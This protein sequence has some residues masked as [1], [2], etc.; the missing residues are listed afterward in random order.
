MRKVIWSL[1]SVTA[2]ALAGCNSST[3]SPQANGGPA[4][5]ASAAAPQANNKVTG[6]ITLREPAQLSPQAKLEV[7][8]VDVSAAPTDANGD[9]TAAV[10]N[11]PIV[12][13]TISPVG[14]FPV[15]FE[16]DFDPAKIN[17][18]NLYVVK[19]HM[20]DGDRNYEMPLQ[21][22]VLTKGASNQVSIQLVAQQTPAEKDLAAFED[23][24]KQIGGMKI[25]SGTK[26]E[27]DASRGWQVFRRDGQVQFIREQVDY[28]DKGFTD[29]DYAYKAGKP[30]VAVQQKKSSKDAKTGST[31]QVSWDV[32]GKPVLHQVL[33]GGKT[34]DLSDSEAASLKSQAENILKLA[35]K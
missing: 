30:W 18:N 35:G 21:A 13:K 34:S 19:A 4:D 25:K 10:P 3:Q 8:L 28:G 24:K 31:E 5:A 2:L 7:S 9:A 1:V 17:P 22:P 12:T 32:D 11:A 26:L 27:K 16:L 29:T 14:S 20:V 33:S 23:L 15:S 6:Q